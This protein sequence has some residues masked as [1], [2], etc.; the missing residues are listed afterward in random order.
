MGSSV[1]SLEQVVERRGGVGPELRGESRPRRSRPAVDVGEDLLEVPGGL[2][3]VGADEP[4]V[5]PLVE[6]HAEQGAVPDELQL[7][8]VPRALVLRAV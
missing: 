6:Q 7:D 1:E 8:R 2:P 4:E 3:R 5:G